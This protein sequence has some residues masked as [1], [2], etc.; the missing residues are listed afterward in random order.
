ME[1][2]RIVFDKKSKVFIAILL[3]GF[4]SSIIF[5]LHGLSINKWDDYLPSQKYNTENI[6]IG[7]AQ[8]IR[9]DEWL[10]STPFIYSQIRHNF[11]H[12]NLNVGVENS[13]LIVHYNLPT[14]HFIS[15][16]KPQNFGFFFLDDERGFSFAWNYK[17]YGLL[18]S[19]FLLLMVFMQS[20]FLLSLLGSFLVYLSSFNQWWFSIP[21]PD[22]II[23]FNMMVVF[24]LYFVFATNPIKIFLYAFGI[25]YFF[26][27]FTIILYPPFQVPLGYLALLLMG[28]ILF[29][30]YKSKNFDYILLKA[31]ITI[32]FLVFMAILFYYFYLDIKEVIN[33]I[34]ETKYPGNRK[35]SGGE[36]DI[37][38]YFSGYYDFLYSSSK[39]PASYGNV[40][41]SSNF[42]FIFPVFIP[43]LL[44]SLFKKDLKIDYKIWFLML[45]IFI[46]SIWVFWGFNPTIAHVTLF[47]K[48]QSTRALLGIGIANIIVTMLLINW[49]NKKDID[50]RYTIEY[51][52]IIFFI[53]FL[54]GKFMQISNSFYTDVKIAISSLIF[55]FIVFTIFTKKIKLFIF[56][57]LLVS[58]PSFFINPLAYGIPQFKEKEFA[59]FI[60]SH[61]FEKGLWVAYDNIAVP[62]Y[63]KALGLNVINGVNFVPNFERLNILDTDEKSKDIYNRY[64]HIVFKPI[65]NELKEVKFNLV[66]ADHYEIFINPCNKK[67]ELLDIKY[68]VFP[69]SY[70]EKMIS[71][72][73]CKMR[74][75]NN[76]PLNNFDIYE[77]I[78]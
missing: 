23:A 75:I 31:T 17:V 16:F 46:F 6:L 21:L 43:I 78:D 30:Y 39:F 59:K 72:K 54:L 61:K 8:G 58:A 70:R 51:Y 41:E 44:V 76:T 50:T 12:N 3:I 63:L 28:F 20:N 64:A 53:L 56:S 32:L 4:I 22:I 65:F 49:L 52:I 29:E 34:L 45:Y 14:H 66:Q 47:E 77:Q 7:K 40:C 27:N 18:F 10:V 69:S 68:F 37:S 36:V 13:P 38:R 11:P 55:T 74:L 57:M 73:G 5:K 67:M 1:F 48:V 60:E 2:N 24:F 62:M 9:S 71:I 35:V 15:L 33:T 19:T 42:F 25:I 26:I